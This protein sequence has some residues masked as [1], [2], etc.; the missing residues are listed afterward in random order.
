MHARLPTT[1]LLLGIAGLVP[2]IVCG[3]W[4]VSSGSPDR[5][6]RGLTALVAYG[7]VILAFLGGV[8]W[9]FVLRPLPEGVVLTTTHSGSRLMLAV[10]P[11]LIGWIALLAPLWGVVD[12]GLVV[13]IVGFLAAV[14]TEAQLNRRGLM[15]QGYMWLRWGLSIVVLMVLI[16]VLTLRLIG[17]TILL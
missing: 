9:G 16:T 2:F 11:P 3:I 4:A 12:L 17:A 7:A 6:L 8:H 13:L 1:A 5:G 14:L 10:M 15:P